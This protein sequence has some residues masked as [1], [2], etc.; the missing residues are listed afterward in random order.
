MKQSEQ[1]LVSVGVDPGPKSGHICF[2][3]PHETIIR[4]TPNNATGMC[5]LFDWS[6]QV[7]YY[8][9]LER[10]QSFGGEGHS[11][12]AGL[13]VEYGRWLGVLA[14]LEYGHLAVTR[15]ITPK[16]WQ[17]TYEQL[18]PQPPKQ[19]Q[20]TDF[21]S[22]AA[23]KRAQKKYRRDRESTRSRRKTALHHIAKDKAL[24][25]VK[26]TRDSADA[27]LLALHAENVLL[28]EFGGSRLE[29]AENNPSPHD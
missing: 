19:P 14:A 11:S 3:G 15:V 23:F 22:P 7:K 10:Q 27:F 5:C 13:L 8:V 29:A 9:A 26:I 6:G 1:I 20:Q 24:L 17:W 21:G 16:K 28:R 18:L 4:S 25:G 12:L 2:I